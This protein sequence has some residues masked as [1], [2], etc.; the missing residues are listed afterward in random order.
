MAFTRA[1]LE[2]DAA[3]EG[4]GSDA[5]VIACRVQGNAISGQ[6]ANLPPASAGVMAAASPYLSA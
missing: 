1:H 5:N 6:S 3:M 2:G 4:R